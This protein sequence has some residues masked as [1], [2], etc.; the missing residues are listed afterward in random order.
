MPQMRKTLTIVI[1]SLLLAV[2]A[3]CAWGYR[4]VTQSLPLSTGTIGLP[5]L[6]E[7]T[8]VY[9]DG[10]HVPHILSKSAEDLFFSQGF[11]TAQDRIWQMEIRRRIA[12]GRVSEIT[13]PEFLGL[14]SLMR[15]IAIPRMAKRSLPV[16]SAESRIALQKYADGVNAYLERMKGRL[17]VEFHLLNCT[18]EPWTA[19][20]CISV[21][22]E[23]C[24]R[25]GPAWQTDLILAAVLERCGQ[26]KARFLWPSGSPDES[27]KW[28][29]RR[30]FA[31]LL[32]EGPQSRPL[33]PSPPFLFP[34]AGWAASGA[35]SIT[36]KPFLACAA[37]LPA[38]APSPFYEIHLEGGLY[39]VTGFSIP[40]FPGVLMGSNGQIAWSVSRLNA[41]VTDLFI[42]TTPP[43][44]PLH[45]LVSGKRLPFEASQETL[46]VRNG[47]PI[48]LRILR[49]H[50]GPVLPFSLF[51]DSV[52]VSLA[53]AG[54]AECDETDVFLRLNRAGSWESFNQILSE[55]TL[56]PFQ[57][58]YADTLGHIGLCAA[59]RIPLR[60][61]GSPFLPRNGSD[62][63]FDWT[64]FV[65]VSRKLSVLDPESGW[66]SDGNRRTAGF[67]ENIL[68]PAAPFSA[69]PQAAL[70]TA[71]F[72]MRNM[73]RLQCSIGSPFALRLLEHLRKIMDAQEIPE[74]WNEQ[75]V[76]SAGAL[77]S[78]DGNL[79]TG[80]PG[81]ALYSALL[82]R[83]SENLLKGT[84]GESLFDAFSGLYPLDLVAVE[85][86]LEAGFWGD[87]TGK[88]P[89][90][91]TRRLALNSIREAHS[92]L[93][94]R[95][96][97]KP[98]SAWSWGALHHIRF[99]HPLG[100]HSLLDRAF[101][102]G[103]FPIGGD[104][105][106]VNAASHLL[107]KPFDIRWAA[108]AR[109]IFD[110]KESG[111]SLALLAGGQSGQPMDEHYD[112][113]IPL[114]LGDL[115]HPVL[116]DTSRIIHSGWKRLSLVPEIGVEHL[117]PMIRR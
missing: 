73:K 96:G 29:G 108:T 17:P 9:R 101:N 82:V 78:W 41:D 45:Y 26:G 107:S 8:V 1:L 90:E 48:P 21:F 38:E 70:D 105:T 27:M 39:H 116:M 33:F 49:T 113:Q 79:K 93:S 110:L 14:D 20:D 80:S 35:R 6:A 72:S 117:E 37:I 62:P 81:A 24:W 103:P 64:G 99:Q 32:S 56:I 2:I 46:N 92:F 76:E 13:G 5:R 75:E 22:R 67:P 16:L 100:A 30:S 69:V 87:G 91:E 40:G 111:N 112:D 31:A 34:G 71:S 115:Y 104:A 36:G 83:L 42:E 86:I 61:K 44:D 43:D 10:Y 68:F 63:E 65:P 94:G 60:G 12:A 89:R 97:D 4:L 95:F 51:H 3:L 53:W 102:Q 55:F 25:T 54:N 66:V 77:F 28:W 85:R 84:L 15:A 88:I 114:Y 52:K 11:V 23:F 109:L 59:G 7:K 106:T 57:F 98:P 74:E 18:P 50:H 47:L 58:L 19:E